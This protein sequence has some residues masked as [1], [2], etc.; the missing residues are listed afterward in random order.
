MMKCSKE[1]IIMIII[2]KRII[3]NMKTM[4]RWLKLH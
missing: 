4:K 3:I 1:I 2:L